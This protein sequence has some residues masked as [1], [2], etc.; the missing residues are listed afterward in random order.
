MFY[1]HF[2]T[3]KDS[4]ENI[5]KWPFMRDLLCEGCI[6]IMYRLKCFGL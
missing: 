3:E 2:D 1:E 6:T 5:V 4:S